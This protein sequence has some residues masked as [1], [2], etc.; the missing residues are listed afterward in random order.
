MLFGVLRNFVRLLVGF[1]HVGEIAVDLETD[2]MIS[3]AV[4]KHLLKDTTSLDFTTS[5][6]GS[7]PSRVDGAWMPQVV[8]PAQAA[9]L[10]FRRHVVAKGNV[11]ARMRFA[12]DDPG[13]HEQ[14]RRVDLLRGGG[15]QF[16]RSQRHD[17]A[18][19]DAHGNAKA[20]CSENDR[21]VFDDEIET[22]G[23]KPSPLTQYNE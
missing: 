13:Q 18:V 23:H 1:E 3:T 15:Q 12:V 17:L 20:P 5:L 8:M 14:A 21:S 11:A 19:L 2:S 22:F 6:K 4:S 10:R 9:A 16:F 7:V